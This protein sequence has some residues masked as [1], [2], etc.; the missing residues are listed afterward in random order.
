MLREIDTAVEK[1]TENFILTMC[2]ECP[3]R[4]CANNTKTCRDELIAI[5]WQ[6]NKRLEKENKEYAELVSNL[7]NEIKE[8]K[9]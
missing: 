3:R 1:C 4:K 8:L 6:E 5:L 9:K 7:H 2:S